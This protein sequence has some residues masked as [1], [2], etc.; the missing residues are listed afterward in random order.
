MFDHGQLY[1][2]TLSG[3]GGT[4]TLSNMRCDSFDPASGLV[5]FDNEHGIRQI[6]S[7]RSG[8]FVYASVQKT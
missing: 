1:Q 7:T 2:I 6:I 4:M 3:G 8:S 5:L